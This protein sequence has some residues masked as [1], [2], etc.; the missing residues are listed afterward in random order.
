[1]TKLPVLDLV[2]NLV[3]IYGES[4]ST[5]VTF[6]MKGS[7]ISG[8]LIHPVAYYNELAKKMKG[9]DT[10]LSNHL[11]EEFE[12][13]AKHIKE[14]LTVN[15]EK[16]KTITNSSKNE[17]ESEIT[18]LYLTKITI[19]SPSNNIVWHDGLLEL[20]EDSIDGFMWGSFKSF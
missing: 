15:D 9:G 13:S 12:K 1:M 16:D 10:E 20:R 8:E 11:G 6:F 4:F 7:I 18:M 17:C 19:W 3:A 14:S 5:N 2:C